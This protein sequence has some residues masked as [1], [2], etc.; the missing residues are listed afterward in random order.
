MNSSQEVIKF[1]T[2]PHIFPVLYCFESNILLINKSM[3]CFIGFIEI[4]FYLKSNLCFSQ[5]ICRKSYLNKNLF[6]DF[7][8]FFKRNKIK[9]I[10]FSNQDIR[11]K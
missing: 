2:F 7:I 1:N 9:K 10:N 6:L 8:T 11:R 5:I 4:I 3:K